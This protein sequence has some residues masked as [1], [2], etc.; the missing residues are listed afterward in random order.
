VG[1]INLNPHSVVMPGHRGEGQNHDVYVEVAGPS[2]VDVQ[3]NF[4]QRWN[5]ASES[6]SPGGSWG[7]GGETVL[8]FPDR[9]PGARGDAVVQIQRT[10]H[11]GRYRDGRATPGGSPFDI[12]AGEQANFEQC[13]DAIAAARRSIYIEN[14]YLEVQ[15]IVDGLR[16]ALQRRVEVI[17]LMPFIPDLPEPESEAE[18]A[19]LAFLASRAAL[20]RY[21]HFLLAG[22]AGPDTD[23]SRKP[24]YVHSKL[25]IVDDEWATVG[26]CNLHHASLFGNSE[27]NVACWSPQFAKLLRTELFREHLDRDVTGV[28]DLIAFRM[29]REVA[30][31][32]R[33]RFCEGH[34]DWQGLAF[35]LDVRN[36]GRSE[37]RVSPGS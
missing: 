30:L 29:F 20:G 18:P 24:V 27:M 10:M 28:D 33:R 6:S 9:I 11:A 35:A 3:H 14:Q 31:E 26:S 16:A 8:A 37:R 21:D 32:N 4:V 25:M 36:Y 19:R 2:T 23:G 17:L 1:G 34:Q 5:E 22:L 7:S 15:P 12:G 13:C